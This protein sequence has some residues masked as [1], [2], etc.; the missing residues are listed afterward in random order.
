MCGR[1]PSTAPTCWTK[2]GSTTTEARPDPTAGTSTTA[3]SDSPSAQTWA[4][5]GPG[6]G[7]PARRRNPAPACRGSAFTPAHLPPAG[8]AAQP[9]GWDGEGPGDGR[10][11]GSPL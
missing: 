7:G 2:P 10:A 5:D 11:I 3:A 9:L 4:C 1:S 6:G 8:A